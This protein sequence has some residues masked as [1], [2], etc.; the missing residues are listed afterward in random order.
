MELE[1]LGMLLIFDA[2]SMGKGSK[3]MLVEGTVM[4]HA[5]MDEEALVLRA[6]NVIGRLCRSKLINDGKK[7]L[8]LH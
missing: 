1:A 2:V 7:F 4:A 3:R 6:L 8:N 5:F